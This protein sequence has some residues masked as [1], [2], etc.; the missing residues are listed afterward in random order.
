MTTTLRIA[1]DVTYSIGDLCREFGVTRRALRFYEEKGLVSPDRQELQRIYSCNDRAR[2]QLIV[3]S[4]RVGL[5]IADIRQI[6]TTHDEQGEEARNKLAIEI[7]E[8]RMQTLMAQRSE[9]DEMVTTLQAE[10]EHLA[11]RLKDQAA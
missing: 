7:F 3:R 4:R 11:E 1:P 8:A 2:L 5:S 6:L 10:R 9:I